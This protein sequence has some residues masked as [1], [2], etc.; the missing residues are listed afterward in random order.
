MPSRSNIEVV[1]ELF[2]LLHERSISIGE[3]G[4]DRLKTEG[5]VNIS[6]FE[7][8]IPN[9][10]ST[11]QFGVK[12]NTN[13][14]LE[15]YNNL[16]KPTKR[17]WRTKDKFEV[18]LYLFPIAPKLFALHYLELRDYALQLENERDKWFHK[19][20]WGLIIDKNEAKWQ[21]RGNTRW[22]PIHEITALSDFTSP[23]TQ[24]SPKAIDIDDPQPNNR[25]QYEQS[26]II[27]DTQLTLNVK[28]LYTFKCQICGTGLLFD[29][30]Q[31]Y[32]EA[33]HLKPLGGPHNGPDVLENI[34]CVCPNHHA[35]LDYGGIQVDTTAFILPLKHR[36]A[37][38]YVQYHNSKIYR[39][40]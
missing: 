25:V 28:H 26:R 36:L 8:T 32:A 27:R 35:L 29:D 6:G 33:H 7:C 12:V 9:V 30:G 21:W 13:W 10:R 20:R 4:K 14:F 16:S 5:F 1:E 2:T 39:G 18:D 23:T 3:D 34:I 19:S 15:P 24:I 31:R 37:E 40:I 22:F 38:D 11:Y 17:S